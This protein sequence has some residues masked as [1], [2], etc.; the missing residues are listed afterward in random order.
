MAPK[1]M[2]VEVAYA[3]PDKQCIIQVEVVEKCSVQE[4]IEQSKIM[5]I[6]PQIDLTKQKVGIF[7]R[8]CELSD[9]LRAGDRVEIYRPL[10]IDPKEARRAKAKK[11][12]K[13]KYSGK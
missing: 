9:G 4:A 6:F 13:L 5:A 3:E 7:S 11:I 2:M 1:K 12:A 10:T 8:P